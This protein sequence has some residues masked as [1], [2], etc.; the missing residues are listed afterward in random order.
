MSN[1]APDV[2]GAGEYGA[3]VVILSKDGSMLRM[4]FGRN[5]ENGGEMIY[6][7][8]LLSPEAQEQL[9]AQLEAL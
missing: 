2:V 7:A 6:G 1:R 5:S 4:A 8:V 3:T 9:K